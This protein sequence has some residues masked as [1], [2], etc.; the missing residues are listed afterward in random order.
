VRPEAVLA[1][2]PRAGGR[3]EERVRGT[4]T[5]TEVVA[6]DEYA[7]VRVGEHTVRARMRE[8]EPVEIDSPA[9]LSFVTRRIHFFDPQ[10]GDR[11]D[12]RAQPSSAAEAGAR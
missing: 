12:G 1:S 10:T 9:E 3:P 6:P 11:L 5:L 8:G 4:V 2:P 7:T